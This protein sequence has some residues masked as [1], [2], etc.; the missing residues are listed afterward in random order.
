MVYQYVGHL[1]LSPTIFL[2]PSHVA[3]LLET[4]SRVCFRKTI[5]HFSACE[6]IINVNKLDSIQCVTILHIS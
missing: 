4:I 1:K 5:L 6:T 3:R 2:I